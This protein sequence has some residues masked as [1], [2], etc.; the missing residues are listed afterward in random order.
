M[1]N[2]SL[3][4]MASRGVQDSHLSISPETS[5]FKRTYKRV[6]NYAIEAIDMDIP[7]LAWNQERHVPISRNGDLLTEMWLVI[8]IELVSLL[9]PGDD[10]VF[11]TKCVG[12]A[13]LKYITL[14]S[15]SS[16]LERLTGDWME[17]LNE[18]GSTI[19]IDTDE[20]V[21]RSDSLEQMQEWSLNGNTCS[22]DGDDLVQL[23]IKL[24]FYFSKARSQALPVIALQYQDL[25]VKFEL[26]AKADL[27]IYSNTD[28]VTLHAT[29]R[30][31]IISGNL[32]CNHAF[33]DA[34]ERRLF[35]SN[36]HEYLITNIQI[37]NFHEKTSGQANVLCNIV[38][39]H[40]SIAFYWY[41]ITDA[42]I[43]RNQYFNWECT[44]GYGDDGLVAA[45]IKFNGAEREK[46]RGALFYKKVQTGLY[47]PKTPTKNLY[48]YS[49]SQHP[50]LWSPGGS[51]NLSR[52]DTTSILMKFKTVD[53]ESNA[54]GAAQVTIYIVNFNILR[55]QAGLVARKYAS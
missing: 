27:L 16:E 34:L 17:I 48:C 23:W 40:P 55:F 39:S 36:A 42:N 52:I 45:T 32:V 37:S 28:N 14:E 8:N 50:L 15:G 6:S 13:C 11:W 43:A 33:V 44:P 49:F 3:Q 1:S 30:G 26:R 25:R 54:Y 22:T 21:L 12:H 20:L 41:C 2:G 53:K 10:M 5:F 46:T 47:W 51:V 31:E 24:P 38:A 4:Q 19:D 35:A 7:T 9:T 18:V 29:E